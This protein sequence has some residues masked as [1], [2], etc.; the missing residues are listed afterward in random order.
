ML[1]NRLCLVFGAVFAMAMGCHGDS[2]SMA[3]APGMNIPTPPDAGSTA[4]QIKPVRQ[5]DIPNASHV[6][7]ARSTGYFVATTRMKHSQPQPAS[8]G[9]YNLYTLEG[10][11]EG[12]FMPVPHAGSTLDDF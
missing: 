3:S 1:T 12:M 5:E 11:P 2:P 7:L 9:Y 4:C 6:R 10:K 8:N